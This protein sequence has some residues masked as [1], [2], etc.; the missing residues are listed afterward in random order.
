MTDEVCSEFKFIADEMLGKLAR[1]LR[2]VGYDTVYYTGEGDSA[3]VQQALQEDRIILTR[4]SHLVERKLARKSLLIRDD[5]P[6]EQF[7]QVV[8]ELEL[9]LDLKSGLFSRCLI[10]NR[11]LFSV[12][13]EDI[14]GR[15]PSYTYS[16]QSKFYE[17][18]DCGRIYWPGT[19][20]DSMMEVISSITD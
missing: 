10:C 9:D 13:K 4:D 12:K 5:E 20:K 18:P 7:R 8:N 19:H 1:W 16:T 17:C 11:E 3:L 2:A 6:R 14:R 15:V